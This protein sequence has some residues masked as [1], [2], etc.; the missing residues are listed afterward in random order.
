MMLFTLFEENI[1]MEGEFVGSNFVSNGHQSETPFANVSN[2]AWYAPYLEHAYN[3]ALLPVDEIKWEVGKS[4]SN[5]EL[6][7]MLA[8]YTAYRMD[9]SGDTLDR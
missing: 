6:I 8:F 4:I 3:L 1:D 5:T 2:T 9:F 7:E